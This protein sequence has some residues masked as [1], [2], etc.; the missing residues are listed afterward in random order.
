MTFEEME[1]K[2]LAL[3]ELLFEPKHKLREIVEWS[4]KI[5]VKR[6]YKKRRFWR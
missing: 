4:E 1:R 6:K 3:R 5:V 2:G